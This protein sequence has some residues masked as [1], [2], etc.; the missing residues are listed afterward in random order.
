[1]KTEMKSKPDIVSDEILVQRLKKGETIAFDVLVERYKKKAY[2]LAYR[3]VSNKEDAEDLSQ[4]AFVRVYKNISKFRGDA[5]FQT[6]FIRILI[7][8]CRTHLRKR[9]I[10]GMF[11]GKKREIS[12]ENNEEKD[13]QIV[14]TDTGGNPEENSSRIDLR[15]SIEEAVNRLSR[16]QKEVFLLKHYQGLKIEEISNV[17]GCATGTVKTHLFR[18][19]NILQKELKDLVSEK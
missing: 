18:A 1:M 12:Y 7:N 19:V 3:L 14:D 4:E 8:L 6:W 16:Q 13:Q 9:Y 17:L 5:S 15:V 10:L 2:F 11:I